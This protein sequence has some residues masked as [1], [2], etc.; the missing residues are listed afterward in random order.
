MKRIVTLL[1]CTILSVA[2]IKAQLTTTLIMSSTPTSIIG[3]W[4]ND[5][6]IINFI[7]NNQTP[8]PNVVIIK[9][10]L[11]TA[12]GA[13]IASVD[14]SRATKY[15]IQSGNN[16]YQA[17][18]VLPLSITQF[19]ATYK[20]ALDKYGKLPAGSY[21]LVV[22]LVSPQG[23]VGITPP[24]TKN[25]IIHP[26]QLPVLI[27]P[28]NNEILRQQEAQTTIIFRWTNKV[29]K[30]NEIVNY[31][32]V[33]FEVYSYQQTIQALRSNQPILDDIVKMQT[34]Y[35]WRPQISFRDDSVKKFV[36]SIQTLDLYGNPITPETANGECLSEPFVFSVQ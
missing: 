23:Y 18:D 3:D 26:V 33:V 25:F 12:D 5:N 19:T 36:W 14:L 29:P 30:V 22:Q 21:Q 7:V 31:R 11:K 28:Y 13:V 32:I 9:T 17:K 27:K 16:I 8:E 34:Q 1:F 24:Q 10:E 35:I 4:H 15:N 2:G 20:N 6:S